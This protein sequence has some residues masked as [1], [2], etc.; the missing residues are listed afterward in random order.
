MAD[1]ER[2]ATIGGSDEGIEMGAEA[3]VSI[4]G[5][6]ELEEWENK[7]R[8]AE[9][10]K[11]SFIEAL[12]LLMLAAAADLF[13]IVAGLTIVLSIIGLIFGFFVS[14]IILMWAILRGGSGYLVFRRLIINIGGWLFDAAFLGILP[15]RTIA[16]LLTIW[17]NNRD[18]NKR[19]RETEERIEE[20]SKSV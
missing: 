16:L 12:L 3:A 20:I 5:L 8:Q 11:I 14:G 19:I 17:V 7:R 1:E 13:E 18:A 4:S 9:R 10:D 2:S 15:I 6:E